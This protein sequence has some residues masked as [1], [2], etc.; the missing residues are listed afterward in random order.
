MATFCRDLTYEPDPSG[1]GGWWT[2]EIVPLKSIDRLSELL[3]DIHHHQAVYTAANAEL[4]H[5]SGCTAEHCRH[6]WMDNVRP[7]EL[8]RPF[9][10]RVGYSG[11]HEDPRC[12]VEDINLQNGRHMWSDG[13]ICPFM[14]S[15]ATWDWLRDT[16]ADF[17]GH[18]SVW[19]VSWMI[20]QQT[21][22]WIAGEHGNTPG[23]HA[24]TIKPNDFCWC[25]SGRKYRKCH[26]QQDS[27]LFMKLGK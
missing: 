2:G 8:L 5:L 26:M 1:S 24:S 13:S 23:Y 11:G 3:D 15:T 20:F 14:S 10:I 12:W 27:V 22:V 16:V 9:S 4:R 25:R 18:V 17:I 19:L 21:A 7:T 6:E